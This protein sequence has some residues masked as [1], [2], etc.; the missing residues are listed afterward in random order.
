MR[1]RALAF[2]FCLTSSVVN[3]D[4]IFQTEKP[5]TC[6]TLKTVVEQ[7]NGLYGEEPYWNGRSKDS[8]YIMFTNPK[9]RSWT[10]VE[11]NDKV[12]CVIGTGEASNM[13]KF[14]FKT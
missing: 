11:Y 10:L 6:S 9:T 14:G 4:E 1:A 3:A 13:L 5:V 12:A 8:K 2:L 7:L